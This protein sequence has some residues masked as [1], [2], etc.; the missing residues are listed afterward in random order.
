MLPLRPTEFL[1]TQRDCI[2]G[3]KGG[4]SITVRRTRL[5]KGKGHVTYRIDGD[6]KKLSYPVPDYLAQEILWYCDNTQ[7][8]TGGLLFGDGKTFSYS[9][10]RLLLSQFYDE[11]SGTETD[12]EPIHLGDTRHLAM[13][14]III[15]GG[16]PSVCRSLAG[17][18]SITQS[19]WYYSNLDAITNSMAF[20][21][22]QAQDA[23]EVVKSPYRLI[24]AEAI[25]HEVPGGRCD[26]PQ[27]EEGDIRPCLEGLTTNM[28]LGECAGCPHFYPYSNNVTTLLVRDRTAQELDNVL[29][30]RMVGQLRG[31]EGCPSP[32]SQE[33]KEL[34]KKHQRNL[35][36]GTGSEGSDT[37]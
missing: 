25:C 9:S 13:I 15:S 29:L 18:E 34:L 10:M 14:G 4:Y 26:A 23:M 37:Q 8:G 21:G 22:L 1:L 32:L 7:P 24:P 11:M 5:K 27:V 20:Q 30:A 36:S 12:A 3:E 35:G 31:G 17:H 16:D 33:W 6:Y 2:S 19:S 28:R